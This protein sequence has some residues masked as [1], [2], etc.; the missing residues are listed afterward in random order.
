MFLQNPH[1]VT[2]F[3]G[4]IAKKLGSRDSN[5]FRE[6]HSYAP[7]YLSGLAFYKLDSLFRSGSI[8]SR[9]KKVRFH[10]LMIFRLLAEDEP[11]PHLT[12]PKKMEKYCDPIIKKLLNPQ[13][14][15][16]LFMEA[17][18]ILDASEMDLSDKQHFKQAVM[19]NKL[20]TT[21]RTI[22]ADKR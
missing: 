11:V 20:L 22:A 17:I 7:Y 8:D 12:S 6:D 4:S 16:N 13:R 14:C 18:E 3:F 9:Y 2:S 1:L 19:V 5:I 21:Y 10:I 15:N